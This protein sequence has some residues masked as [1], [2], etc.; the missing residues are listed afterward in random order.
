[1]TNL[2]YILI[3]VAMFATV[4]ALA[5]GIGGFGKGGTF[6]AKNGNKMMRLRL[7]FQAIAVALI[8]LYVFLKN[9]G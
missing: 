2:V 7:L 6:N 8:V 3:F 4:A 1:M 9:G 5:V